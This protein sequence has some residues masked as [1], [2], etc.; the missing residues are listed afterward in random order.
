MNFFVL[1]YIFSLITSLIKIFAA[2]YFSMGENNNFL[3]VIISCRVTINIFFG[4]FN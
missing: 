4:K 1:I 3:L 2:E